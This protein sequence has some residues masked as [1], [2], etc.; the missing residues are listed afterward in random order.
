VSQPSGVK[1][2][3]KP[4]QKNCFV[5]M[6]IG[7]ES[8]DTRRRSDQVLKHIIKPAAESCG[9]SAIRADEIDKPGLIT[10]QVIQRV[11]DDPLVIADLSE[12]NP[13]VFYELAIRH[14]IRKPLVQ[15][16]EKGERIPFDVAGTRTVHVDHKDLDSV[17]SAK[18]EIVKQIKQLEADPGDLETP[19]SISRDLQILKQS[20]NPKDRGIADLLSVISEMR[21]EQSKIM[22]GMDKTSTDRMTQV[23]RR[24]EDFLE[25]G[26]LGNRK[27]RMPFREMMR[28]MPEMMMEF[29]KEGSG[30]IGIAIAASIFKD[31]MPWIYEV[32]MEAYRQNL[33]GEKA[34]AR[35]SLEE[36]RQAARFSGHPMFR[37]FARNDKELMFF[38]QEIDMFLSELEHRQEMG[39][40]FR[41]AK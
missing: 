15:I 10:S 24:L 3:Q 39:L 20:D 37:E 41:K 28:H 2:T 27:R 17:S 6:P 34:K 9:Y 21:A 32:G 7:E 8:S 4:V 36:F 13:N 22:E 1:L 26:D 23:I 35:R 25:G 18:E 16:I 29:S 31:A 40:N 33:F 5:I 30:S 14:A 11:I 12:T 38:G 19:I